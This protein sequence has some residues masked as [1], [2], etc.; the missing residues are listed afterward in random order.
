MSCV[1]FLKLRN[2][3]NLIYKP[4][5]T[6]FTRCK[7]YHYWSWMI[8]LVPFRYNAVVVYMSLDCIFFSP[9]SWVN[10]YILNIPHLS[11]NEGDI[12]CNRVI[13]LA[14][15]IAITVLFT[16]SNSWPFMAFWLLMFSQISSI[17]LFAVISVTFYFSRRKRQRTCCLRFP[18]WPS[19][20]LGIT[21]HQLI[22]AM[23]WICTLMNWVII[24][25]G[26]DSSAVQCQAINWTNVL[27]YNQ[28]FSYEH[29]LMK[30]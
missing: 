27:T 1:W 14:N 10:V 13:Q 7:V 5:H 17:L 9:S 18:L 8:Y 25:S 22:A 29:T 21:S 30:F 6:W 26:N 15:S 28:M 16:T 20:G 2:E 3:H 12:G 24:G 11:G 19:I 23:W 4:K